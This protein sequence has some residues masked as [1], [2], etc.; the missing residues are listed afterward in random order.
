MTPEIGVEIHHCNVKLSSSSLLDEWKAWH[1]VTLKFQ[2]SSHQTCVKITSSLR[3]L[4]RE[5]KSGH[6][7]LCWIWIHAADTWSTLLAILS[8]TTYCRLILQSSKCKIWNDVTR[9]SVCTRFG[10]FTHQESSNLYYLQPPQWAA[11]H[12][13]VY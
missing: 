10:T 12:I 1:L 4:H 3:W 9:F 11:H 13:H 6:P 5:H 7:R 2:T 8:N